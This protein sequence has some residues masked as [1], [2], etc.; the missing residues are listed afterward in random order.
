[1]TFETLK[2]STVIVL[3]FPVNFFSVYR[4]LFVVISVFFYFFRPKVTISKQESGELI[5]LSSVL[6]TRIFSSSFNTK[7]LSNLK[8][9]FILVYQM[10]SHHRCAVKDFQ[11]RVSVRHR[12]PNSRK[13]M[14]IFKLWMNCVGNEI[15]QHLNP[16]Y[17]STEQIIDQPPTSAMP[18]TQPVVPLDLVQDS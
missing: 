13:C 9:D 3:A 5:D 1:M 14:T 10:P 17:S 4:T 8:A 6:I 16:I 2:L 18:P 7:F 12:F 15:L 11:D